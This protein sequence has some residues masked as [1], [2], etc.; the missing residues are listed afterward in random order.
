VLSLRRAIGIS[1]ADSTSQNLSVPERLSAIETKL[2]TLVQAVNANTRE[3][4]ILKTRVSA[5]FKLV[6]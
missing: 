1:G 2:E 5:L 4:S 3:R 6:N